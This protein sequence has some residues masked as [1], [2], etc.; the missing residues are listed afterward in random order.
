MH[1]MRTTARPGEF[2]AVWTVI[3]DFLPQKS[4]NCQR[5]QDRHGDVDEYPY[6]TRAK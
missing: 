1:Q 2:I 4:H 6:V 3:V 5:V